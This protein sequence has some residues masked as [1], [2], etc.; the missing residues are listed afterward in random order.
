MPTRLTPLRRSR[1]KM[2]IDEMNDLMVG[3][4]PCRSIFRN[5]TERRDCWLRHREQLLAWSHHGRRPDAWWRFE[6]PVPYPGDGSYQEATLYEA[7][8]L[9]PEEVASVM[10][11]WRHWFDHAQEPDFSYCT[12]NGWLKDEEARRAQY[13]WAGIP[14]ALIKQWTEERKGSPA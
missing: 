14:H 9:R 7:G 4:A 8:L 6:S 5:E 3:Y 11:R 12:G 2:S 1:H 10:E 13:R